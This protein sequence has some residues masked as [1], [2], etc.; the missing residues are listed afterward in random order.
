MK[1]VILLKGL[2]SVRDSRI[3]RIPYGVAMLQ[4]VYPNLYLVRLV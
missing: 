1:Y 3:P 4:L 2:R